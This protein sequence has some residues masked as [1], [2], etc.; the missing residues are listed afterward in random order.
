MKHKMHDKD[1]IE[2]KIFDKNGIEVEEFDLVKVYHFTGARRK[3]YYMY[4]WVKKDKL[5]SDFMCY[6]LDEEGHH[7][8][9]WCE[10][11]DKDGKL[12]WENGEVIQ[13]DNWG[14]LD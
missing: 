5:T 1:G 9:I 6:S 11:K 4:K 14:K 10:I 7:Y 13:S 8:N 12:V 3:K 2:I